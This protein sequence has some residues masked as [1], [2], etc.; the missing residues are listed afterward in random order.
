MLLGIFVELLLLALLIY[1]PPLQS[2]FNTAPLRAAD[3]AFAFAWAPAIVVCDELR[4][5]WIR[6]RNGCLARS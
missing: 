4:K 3:L 5:W 1:A 2:V 6:R